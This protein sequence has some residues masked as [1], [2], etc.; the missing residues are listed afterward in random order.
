MSASGGSA[1]ATFSGAQAA[2]DFNLVVADWDGSTP[3]SS[4]T[5]SAGN[6]YSLLGGSAD[7]FPASATDS[8]NVVQA[9]YYARNIVAA[10]SNTVTVNF[11]GPMAGAAVRLAEYRGIDPV[12]PI[13]VTSAAYGIGVVADS[14]WVTTTNPSDL[15]V[16]IELTGGS[17]TGPAPNY[18]VRQMNDSEPAGTDLIEDEF[19]TTT[20]AY[21]ATGSMSPQAWWVMQFV[22]LRLAGGGDTNTQALTAPTGL[23][24]A[25]AA[26]SQITLNWT[27]STDN[28][29]VTGYL[30]ERC[31]GASCVN[32]AQVGS[33]AAGVTTYSDVG[34]QPSTTYTYRVRATDV[35]TLM[36]AY[37]ATA[38]AATLATTG[39][40]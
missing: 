15:L 25:A 3:I 22:A 31:A 23:T 21:H 1:S 11:N 6:T 10:T 24:A 18:T 37:S 26:G 36:S 33:V 38:S 7:V 20:G 30:V 17:S 34:L 9:T 27:G 12:N 35:A 13:D 2:G 40:N 29:G 5:D 39:S 4:V 32:F 28:I 14:G 16:G 8:P 19:V